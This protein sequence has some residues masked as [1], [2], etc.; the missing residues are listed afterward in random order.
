[1]DL[2]ELLAALENR[3]KQH[4]N[5]EQE[6][7]RLTLENQKLQKTLDATFDRI[8]ASILTEGIFNRE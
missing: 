1:M 4:A 7:M 3:E 5:L 6:I 8:D 2:Q